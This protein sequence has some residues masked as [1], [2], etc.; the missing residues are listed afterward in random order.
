MKSLIFAIS[1]LASSTLAFTQNT[2]QIEIDYGK[3]TSAFATHLTQ[4][5][6][7]NFLL[8]NALNPNSSGYNGASFIQ[9]NSVGTVTKNVSVWSNDTVTLKSIDYFHN[10]G[11]KSICPYE[12]FIGLQSCEN[13]NE[14]SLTSKPGVFILNNE[15]VELILDTVYDLIT[16]CT[17]IH[18][19]AHASLNDSTFVSIELESRSDT[20]KVITRVN[21]NLTNAI[22]LPG[23]Y[24]TGQLST[25]IFDNTDSTFVIRGF[26]NGHQDGEMLL[27]INLSGEVKKLLSI[28]P[29]EQITSIALGKTNV[30]ILVNV[31]DSISLQFRYSEILAVPQ[32]VGEPIEQVRFD[33]TERAFDLCIAGQNLLVV[34]D[35]T[36]GYTFPLFDKPIR[37]YQ[38][39]TQLQT[40][41]FNDYGAPDYKPVQI[42]PSIDNGFAI[43]GTVYKNNSWNTTD[44]DDHRAFVVK[45]L[46]K[47][48][49]T[50]LSLKQIEA[51]Q[52]DFNL[53]PNPSSDNVTISSTNGGISSTVEVL[54][55]TGRVMFNSGKVIFPATL[56]LSSLASGHYVIKIFT[57][58]G[59]H[60][61]N[62]V[63]K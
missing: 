19:S 49:D 4:T 17:I 35:K 57:N 39:D 1:L 9:L 52:A 61:K 6:D 46:I 56:N 18:C 40:M 32:L 48:L 43:L 15:T 60:Y 44:K 63:K 21:H 14:L 34:T 30:F 42:I 28:K 22:P 55:N 58:E 13:V 8:L 5:L 38:L 2:F 59:V 16:P 54:D 3:D 11:T 62:L 25:F 7:G 41:L 33:S 20:T 10:T 37:V 26:E 29:W 53:F 31:H 51:N 45:G 23:Y 50:Q 12:N 47:D 27:K 36:P 24:L